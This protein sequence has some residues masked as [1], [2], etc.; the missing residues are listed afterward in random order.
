MT[1]PKSPKEPKDAGG[2]T[3]PLFNYLAT[4][5][6]VKVQN[7]VRSLLDFL[8][9]CERCVLSLPVSDILTCNSALNND[10]ALRKHYLHCACR[11]VSDLFNTHWMMNENKAELVICFIISFYSFC[12][13]SS[14]TVRSKCSKRKKKVKTGFNKCQRAVLKYEVK[15]LQPFSI[16]EGLNK[17]FKNFKKGFERIQ[18]WEAVLEVVS[19]LIKCCQ[20]PSL[21]TQLH[22]LWYTMGC[23]CLLLIFLLL[24]TLNTSLL[25]CHVSQ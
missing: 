19:E 16:A 18:I 25:P 15:A 20:T 22:S 4:V 8:I 6:H 10:I 24:L 23:W 12:S 14:P 1:V 17:L 13:C 5:Q 21:I 11:K 3:S 9:T 7:L 2:M